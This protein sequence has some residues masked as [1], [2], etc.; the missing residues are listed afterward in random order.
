MSRTPALYPTLR[1]IRTKRFRKKLGLYKQVLGF[2]DVTMSIYLAVFGVIFLIAIRDQLQGYE[3]FFSIF[4]QLSFEW[5]FTIF[6]AVLLRSL[7]TSFRDPGFYIT[8][9]EFQLSL[10][11]YSREKIWRYNVITRLTKGMA[12]LILI[13]L[14][15]YFLTPIH[16]ETIILLFIGLL[17]GQVLG[18]IIQWRLFQISGIRKMWAVLGGMIFLIGVRMLVLFSS[19]A[20]IP[21]MWLSVTASILLAIF[22]MTN[23]PLKHADWSK[24]IGYS[25]AVIWN[26]LIIQ[27]MTKVSIKP[28][29]K[30][31][32][33]TKVFQGE[34]AKKPFSYQLSD[35]T[36]RLWRTLFKNQL[37]VVIRTLGV[38]FLVIV[39][40]G[41]QGKWQL[42]VAVA[43]TVFVLNQIASSLF[44]YQF[45]QPMTRVFPWPMPDWFKSYHKWFLWVIIL[46]M[47]LIGRMEFMY[48]L[49]VPAV[50]LNLLFCYLWFSLDLEMCVAPKVRKLRGIWRGNDWFFAV[51]IIGMIVVFLTIYYPWLSLVFSFVMIAVRAGRWSV[52]PK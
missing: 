29:K 1:W 52:I 25:D 5:V 43:V 39:V 22:L 8:T 30:Y 4:E 10:L 15:L 6:I 26:M 51:R 40:F 17:S 19:V 7:F 12:Q 33:I 50:L 32:L 35:I 20:V 21:V 2:L 23:Q 45:Q 24:V 48:G 16:S 44:M 47:L 9:T 13:H 34:R 36:P 37:D 28:P 14:F 11:P 27:Q 42:G 31:H 18:L 3:A 49:S 41:F 46:L 38:V